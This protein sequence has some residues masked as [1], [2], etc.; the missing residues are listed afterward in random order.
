[1]PRL[2]TLI[3]IVAMFVLAPRAQ[4]KSEFLDVLTETYK[5]YADKLTEHSCSSCHTDSLPS[6]NLYGKQIAHELVAANTKELTPEI[7][8]K[9]EEEDA[10]QDGT[11]N[12]EEIKAGTDPA[13]P[14]SGGKPGYKPTAAKA[15]AEESAPVPK[16]K[17]LFPK[18][19][20]HPA[21]VHFPI[22]LFIVGLF[23]DFLGMWRKHKTMLLAGWY[24]LLLGAISTLASIL[25]GVT[26]MFRMHL[27]FSGLIFQHLLLACIGT[28][29]MWLMV[30]LRYNRHEKMSVPLRVTYY[31]LAVAGV[32]LIAY[33]AHLGGVFVYGE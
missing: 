16:Q 6:L 29:I 25:S 15:P 11:S 7:L 14:K 18:N 8:K 13:D 17:P 5:P 10:D 19:A 22:A 30:A 31:V 2:F 23:L 4:A 20:F 21:I 12:L 27:P 32:I 24:N 26:A 33:S 3:A 1:M 9:V 28:V